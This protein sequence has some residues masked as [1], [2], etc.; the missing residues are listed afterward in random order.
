MALKTLLVL[1]A[2]QIAQAD[3]S[4]Q[5]FYKKVTAETARSI[6]AIKGHDVADAGSPL[7]NEQVSSICYK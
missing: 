7:F 5:L 6:A 1:A 3:S 2:V 4:H